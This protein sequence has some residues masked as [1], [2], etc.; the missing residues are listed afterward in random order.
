MDIEHLETAPET[1]LDQSGF[2]GEAWADTLIDGDPVAT[3][4]AFVAALRKGPTRT[5][6]RTD[7]IGLRRRLYGDNPGYLE[8]IDAD[9]TAEKYHTGVYGISH[10]SEDEIAHPEKSR[11]RP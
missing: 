9:E 11:M 7:L 2:E 4:E 3:R 8:T 1:V 10:Q 6:P 5:N